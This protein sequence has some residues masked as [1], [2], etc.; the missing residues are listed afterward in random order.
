MAISYSKDTI[1][2]LRVIPIHGRQVQLKLRI[3]EVDRSKAEQFGINFFT[4]G[5]TASS[6]STQQFPTSVNTSSSSG[7]GASV[8][9]SNPLNFFLYNYKLNLGMTLEDLE[10]RQILQVLAEPTLTTLSGTPARFLSG[11]EFPV[12]V[13]QG[14]TGNSTAISI[15]YRPYG[16]RVDF[17]PTVNV[18]GTIRLKIAPEVSTLDYT[19]SVTISGSTIPALSTRRAETEVEI[20][21][22][23]SFVLS[24]LLDHRTT[25]SLASVP[26]IANIPI[27][28]ELFRSKDINH[29]IVELVVL[30]TATLVDPLTTI[31]STSEPKMALP[32]MDSSIFDVRIQTSSKNKNF[33]NA[34]PAVIQS[35]KK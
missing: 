23:E 12:P 6:T 18:D 17:T 35:D 13:V 20:K 25:D 27:L 2:A 34:I 28:G 22:G 26:G 11:G 32:N 19:N 30:V 14:G 7:S 5:R 10:N 9:I 24:G 8:S 15:M 29:S 31:S 4:G 1:N 3:I 21:S 16:V 33:P